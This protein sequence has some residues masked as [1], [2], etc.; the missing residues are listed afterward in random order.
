[1]T[2]SG[3]KWLTG[4]GIGCLAL[5]L[6]LVGFGTT[7]YLHVRSKMQVF[8]EARAAS[9]ELERSF[10]KP[11][12]FC[13]APGAIARPR[14]EAFLEARRRAAPARASLEE[15][16]TTFEQDLRRVR[17]DGHS[18]LQI[19]GVVRRAVGLIPKL[20]EFLTARNQA[21]LGARMGAGEYFYLYTLTYYSW[22]G[23]SPEDGPPFRVRGRESVMAEEGGDARDVR[24]ERRDA[25]TAEVR[26]RFVAMFHRQLD[27]Q[28]AS[29][30][31]AVPDPWRRAVL[32]ELSA[33]ESDPHRLPWQTGL[34]PEIAKSLEPYR[35]E[36]EASYSALV[37]P[38]ELVFQ[39]DSGR[40]RD[41][42]SAD[43]KSR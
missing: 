6:V 38:L 11:E 35:Q 5:L 19:V 24:A 30:A 39:V 8:E 2:D 4:C 7:F 25:L 32:G 31:E 40:E 43:R 36:L 14:L 15:S 22:L 3:S 29:Q 16:F 26:R 34:P 21:L 18:A 12:D 1:M 27:R 20:G 17:K 33:L 10:G 37:N 13:P 9:T 28:A 23:R 42:E 41:A